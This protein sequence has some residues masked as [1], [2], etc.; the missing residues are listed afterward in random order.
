MSATQ[1]ATLGAAVR[2][3]PTKPTGSIAG[4]LLRAEWTKIR[5]VRSTWWTLFTAAATTIGL[6]AMVCAIF[7][8]QFDNLTPQDM[9]TFNPA[10]FSVTGGVLAQFAIAVLGVLVITGEYGTRMIRTTFAA[11]PQRLSVLAAKATVF[12]ALSL[13]VTTTACFIAFFIGQA[14]LSGKGVGISIGAPGALRTVVGTSLYLGVLGLLSLGVGAL[15]R[16]TAGAI[17]AVVGI[18][19]VLPVLT[20]LLPSSLDAIQKFLPANAGQAIIT[21]GVAQGATSLTPWIGLGVF[22]LYAVVVLTAAAFALVRRDA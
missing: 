22:F 10:S 14:I 1:T 16:K 11:A 21:G 9:A 6:S 18:I 4:N 20:S 12:S 15:L 13:A 3:R 5:S 19:F 2:A 8:A 17:S 7:V